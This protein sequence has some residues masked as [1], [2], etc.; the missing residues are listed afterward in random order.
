MNA[1]VNAIEAMEPGGSLTVATGRTDDGGLRLA[2]T[3]TGGG[4]DET[5]RAKAFDLFFST[6]PG[7][8][9]LGMAIIRS[10]VER[11]GGRLAIDSTP[12]K[13]TTIE[14]TLPSQPDAATTPS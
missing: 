5:T 11:H 9:G 4:M 1:V 6:K 14:I 3:D 8:T 13:G 7:G 10:A 12:G 2:I